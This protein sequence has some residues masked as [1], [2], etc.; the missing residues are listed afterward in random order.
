MSTI[1]SVAARRKQLGNY[2]LLSFDLNWNSVRFAFLALRLTFGTML[3]F[4]Y[5]QFNGNSGRMCFVFNKTTPTDL[6]QENLPFDVDAATVDGF[7]CFLTTLLCDFLF[8]SI[9]TSIAISIPFSWSL[10]DLRWLRK[11]KRNLC[12]SGSRALTNTTGQLVKF[13]ITALTYTGI[14]PFFI[15]DLFIRFRSK[16]FTIFW[17]RSAFTEIVIQRKLTQV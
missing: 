3:L 10:Q 17:Q 1:I 2:N 5:R 11:H 15:Y 4:N 13:S 16:H 8:D 7:F 9:H 6:I 12:S 14:Q